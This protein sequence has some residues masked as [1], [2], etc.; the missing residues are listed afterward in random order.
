MGFNESGLKSNEISS[1]LR[2]QKHRRV[3][4]D[5]LTGRLKV[6][7]MALSPL[8]QAIINFVVRL[9][10]RLSR[11]TKRIAY[12]PAGTQLQSKQLGTLLKGRSCSLS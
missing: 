9:L 6:Y 11:T 3:A 2:E 8:H 4:Y 12:R 5:R 7:S 10:H 1:L